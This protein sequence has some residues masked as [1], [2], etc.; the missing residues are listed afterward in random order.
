[1][2]HHQ[3]AVGSRAQVWHGVAAKTSGGLRKAD[4]KKT[5][6]GRIVSKKASEAAKKGKGFKALKRLGLVVKKGVNPFAKR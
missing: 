5:K 3:L 1:M 4:L 6:H 2:V